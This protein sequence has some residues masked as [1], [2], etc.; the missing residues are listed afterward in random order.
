MTTNFW[1]CYKC[2]TICEMH[3][4][5][6]KTHYFEKGYSRPIL[7]YI[8]IVKNLYHSWNTGFHSL[9]IYSSRRAASGYKLQNHYTTETENVFITSHRTILWIILL[10][11]NLSL[12]FDSKLFDVN[13]TDFDFDGRVNNLL[14]ITTIEK[15][16]I[17]AP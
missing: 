10:L 12:W 6:Q 7:K 5:S 4:L 8:F 11:L 16:D 9:R 17:G 2:F 3:I 13:S 15:L 1:T 14:L